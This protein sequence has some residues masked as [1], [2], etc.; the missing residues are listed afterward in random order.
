MSK[1]FT[2][3]LGDSS[4]PKLK[5]RIKTIR[6]VDYNDFDEFVR[7]IYGG[8]YEFVAIQEANNSSSYTFRP[9]GKI[10]DYQEKD[11]QKIKS[12]KY[13]NYCNHILFDLLV[14]EGYLEPG[15]YLVEVFW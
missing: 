1:K 3:W 10:S 11:V 15:E 13:P 4:R 2:E 8:D 7:S 5:M 12:G 14:K 9:D 6:S